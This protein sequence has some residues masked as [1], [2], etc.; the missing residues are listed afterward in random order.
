MAVYPDQTRTI[1]PY[2]SYNSNVTSRLTRMVTN[3]S[4]CLF[5]SNAIDVTDGTTDTEVIVGT[6][7][8]FKDDIL[9]QLDAQTTVDFEDS[10]F[11]V[12]FGAG[13]NEAGYYYILLDYEYVKANPA[14]QASIKILKPSQRTTLLTDRHLFLKAVYITGTPPNLSVTSLH[15][16]DPE[17]PTNQREFSPL[18][19]GLISTLPTWDTSYIGRI[20]MLTTNGTLYWGTTTGWEQFQSSVHSYQLAKDMYGR[21]DATDLLDQTGDPIGTKPTVVSTYRTELR[22]GSYLNE[23]TLQAAIADA[24]TPATL[25]LTA[26]DWAIDADTTSPVGITLMVDNGARLGIASGVDLIIDGV[27]LA[28]ANQIFF[29][30]GTATVN[31]YPR[32]DAWWGLPQK[33]YVHNLDSGV[34]GEWN[35]GSGNSIYYNPTPD[36]VMINS[37]T[38]KSTSTLYVAEI[39]DTANLTLIRGDT[40]IQDGNDL[41]SIDFSGLQDSTYASPYD[42]GQIRA[43]AD[44]TWVN[45]TETGTYLEFRTTPE[46]TINLSSSTRAIRMYSTAVSGVNQSQLVINHDSKIAQQGVTLVVSNNSSSGDPVLLMKASWATPSS[47]WNIGRIDFG[48]GGDGDDDPQVGAYI[49]ATTTEGWATGDFG[50]Q[51]E[52]ATA[53]NG[54]SSTSIHMTIGQDGLVTL[55]SGTGINEFSI[56][57]TLTGDSDDAVPTE[58]AV[59]TYVD[60]E[61]ATVYSD[62]TSYVDTEIGNANATMKSYVDGEISDVYSDMTSYVN[63]EI[64]SSSL[65]WS[66]G[67]LTVN[68]ATPDVSQHTSYRATNT[69]STTITDFT[70]GASGQVLFIAFSNSNTTVDSNTNIKLQG[71]APFVASGNC[72]L[73]LLHDGTTW[74]E[75]SRSINA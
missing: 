54:S 14:P 19:V 62:M 56:D 16:S 6:G 25:H 1:D 36:A 32:D 10:D 73:T 66:Y 27:V 53:D 71:G 49:Q 74:F 18:Y 63:A 72:T 67:L 12:N 31:S 39:N 57:G 40:S 65:N 61:I 9:V 26:G 24:T 48:S 2:A 21:P 43:V 17:N 52:F 30:A 11:Y 68:S 22:S 44:G 70:N 5:S 41:G 46:G 23:A 3:D 50:T 51:L 4:N 35:K 20:F 29:G 58:K 42:K 37:S 13:F 45:G 75:L 47:G 64:A 33:L 8:C 7:I 69:V 34:S 60:T 38:A 15:D 28:P 55:G 59:K